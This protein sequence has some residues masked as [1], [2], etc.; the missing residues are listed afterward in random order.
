MADETYQSLYRRYRPHRFVEVLGQDHVTVALCNAVR[1]GRVG[2]GYLFSGPRG[3]GKTSTARIL[4]KALNCEK[5]DDGEP[6]GV[7]ESCTSV[8]TGN[9]FAVIEMDAASNNGV[10][11]MRDL[12]SRASLGTTGLR[13]VYIIDEVHML[14]TAASNTLLKTL[15]EPPSHVV[16]VLATTDPQKVLPTII[17][18]VQHFQFHLLAADTLG[19]LVR[20]INADAGLGLADDDLDKVVR[21]GSGSARDAL[22]V[23]DQAAALGGAEDEVPVASEVLEALVERDS[24]RALTAVA[25]G[26]SAGRDP[27]RLAEEVLAGLRDAFL[28][29][30]APA[31]VDLPPLEV[32]RVA[33][34]GRKLGPAALVRAMETLGE[35]LTEMREALDPRVT[36]EVALVRV[37]AP[38]A[39]VSV[40]ALLERVERLER[41]LA[42]GE[43]T[44]G[45]RVQE[46]AAV[47]SVAAAAPEATGPPVAPPGPAVVQGQPGP[48]NLPK[49]PPA[50][51][52]APRPPP[53]APPAPAAV[54]SA[55]P[56]PPGGRSLGSY[57]G[58]SR[59]AA[60]PAPPPATAVVPV[61]VT[62]PVT[63]A[64]GEAPSREEL[65]KAWG[66]TIL[67][68]LS[69]RA[70]SRYA[71]GRF[72][73]GAEGRAV[74]ALPGAVHRDQCLPMQL[75]VEAAL[76]G[77]FGRPVAL[78]LVADQVPTDESDDESSF[79]VDEL[80]DAP[81]AT[82]SPAERVK[83]AFP[84]AE[85]VGP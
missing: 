62:P 64:G 65:T 40:A 84:G 77:H 59:P 52:S 10:D 23:L 46:T 27:R 50:R 31:L 67:G 29:G 26:C 1:E 42:S 39:D 14:S 3:T 61:P 12:V 80:R 43:P 6:C 47:A 21:R 9:S 71:A 78:E 20:T 38:E 55:P 24:A 73:P 35:A 18:R 60:S 70:R 68:N 83:S 74:F 75:E 2:Q 82:D 16:F 5:L 30:R 45:P 66:D 15:E 54:V 58:G 7:C 17:S 4:G 51:P 13:K 63:P 32:E 81:A 49:V 48:H 44:D 34:V 69:A 37:T 79:S 36:L 19:G 57:R 28:A 25:G 33:E 53:P 56:P 11:A 41:R 72:L 8:T 85:E 76:T 22:S